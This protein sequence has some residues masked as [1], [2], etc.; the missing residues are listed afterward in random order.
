MRKA[1]VFFVSVRPVRENRNLQL[2]EADYEITKTK[3][4]YNQ[5]YFFR[6]PFFYW[7]W[8]REGWGEVAGAFVVVFS[9]NR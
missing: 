7:F 8:S 3:K 6:F 2:Q 9:K 5:Q 4:G 1:G